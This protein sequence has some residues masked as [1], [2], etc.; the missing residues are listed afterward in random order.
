MSFENDSY[1][2]ILENLHDGLYFVDRDRTITYW[3]NAAEQISGFTAVEVVGT[4]CSN[5]ILTHVD[6]DGNKL[7][8]G[9]CPLAATISDG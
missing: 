6:S 1:E 5:N 8:T 3:N 7:C 9:M 2:R 4:S